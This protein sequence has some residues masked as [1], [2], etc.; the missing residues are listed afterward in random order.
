[1]TPTHT[2]V[3]SEDRSISIANATFMEQVAKQ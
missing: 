1:V 3:E 2:I